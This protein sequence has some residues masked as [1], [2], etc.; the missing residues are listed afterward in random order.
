MEH[1][2]LSAHWKEVKV[3]DTTTDIKEGVN[4]GVW[5]VGFIIGSSEMGLS[6]VE[7]TSLSEPDKKTI[8]S[9]SE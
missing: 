4:A 7:F 1:L 9:K 8:I 5:S 2:K 6:L 3:G